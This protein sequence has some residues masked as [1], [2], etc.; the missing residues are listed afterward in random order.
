[1]VY[2]IVLVCRRF[3]YNQNGD[4]PKRQHIQNGDTVKIKLDFISGI[5]LDEPSH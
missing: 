5:L 2:V 4:T 3:G 1:M